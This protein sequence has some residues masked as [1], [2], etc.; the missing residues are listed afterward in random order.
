M[1][2]EISP[3]TREKASEI[4]KMLK[5]NLQMSQKNSYTTNYLLQKFQTKK[6]ENKTF[7]VDYGATSHIVTKKENITNPKY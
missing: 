4:G 1:A 3:I 7:V 2:T 5:R 6:Y